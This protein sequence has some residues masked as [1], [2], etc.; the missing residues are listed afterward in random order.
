MSDGIGRRGFMGGA[1]AAIAA[2]VGLKAAAAK[3]VGVSVQRR[4]TVVDSVQ[5]L[6]DDGAEPIPYT[7]IDSGFVGLYT[8]PDGVTWTVAKTDEMIAELQAFVSSPE[9]EPPPF[10]EWWHPRKPS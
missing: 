7:S 3:P 9:D 8:S 10:Q 5:H 1:L 4:A 6:V 2:A